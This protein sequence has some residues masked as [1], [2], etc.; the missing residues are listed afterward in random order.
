L[1][2]DFIDFK[3]NIF[4]SSLNFDFI[5]FKFNI[6]VR[7]SNARSTIQDSSLLPTLEISFR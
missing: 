7:I 6:F 3:S 4:V 2:F 1:N 5:D